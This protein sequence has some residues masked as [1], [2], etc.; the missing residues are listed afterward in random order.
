MKLKPHQRQHITEAGQILYS[1]TVP[2]GANDLDSGM[3]RASKMC[4]PGGFWAE[5]LV[6]GPPDDKAGAIV[7]LRKVIAEADA[8]LAK[9]QADLPRSEQSSTT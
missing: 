9:I 4:Q 1:M 3:A 6:P 8:E 7:W 5:T 2:L